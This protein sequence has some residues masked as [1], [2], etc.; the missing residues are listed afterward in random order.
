[1]FDMASCGMIY[2]PSFIMVGCSIHAILRLLPQE[3]ERLQ[4]WCY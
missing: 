2:I 3:F 4:C 1:M